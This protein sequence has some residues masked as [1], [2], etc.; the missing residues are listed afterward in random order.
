MSGFTKLYSSI[1]YSTVWRESHQTRIVWVTMLVL[2]D[3]HGYVGV[4][5]PGLA[6]VAR[7]TVGEC[8]AALALFQGP[9]PYSRTQA[10][11]GRRIKAVDGGWVLLN[12]ESYRAGR[13]PEVRRRQ[14]CEAQARYRRKATRAGV[15]DSAD[16]GLH[17]DGQPPSAQ[18][19]AE[20]EAEAK[21]ERGRRS[22]GSRTAPRD[23]VLSEADLV[24]EAEAAAKGVD[25][26]RSRARWMDHEYPRP[27]VDFHRC[28]RNWLRGDM[29]RLAERQIPPGAVE[30]AGRTRTPDF[31]RPGATRRELTQRAGKSKPMSAQETLAAIADVHAAIG[32]SKKGDS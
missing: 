1:V 6:D 10:H 31:E 18:A 22:R 25:V 12:Y 17:A 23:F 24:V 16:A 9:D 3:A 8:E 29:D 32:S 27:Y 26:E 11:E 30:H 14:N 19:E 20:A 13:D 2:A 5:I 21:K 28:W 7:V 15:A 4:S